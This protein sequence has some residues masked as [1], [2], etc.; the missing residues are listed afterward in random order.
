MAED[1][2]LNA[3]DYLDRFFDEL[4]AEVRANPKLAE[5]LV[6]SLGGQVV[7]DDETRADIAKPY[8]LA[9]SATKARFYAVFGAMKPGQLRKILRDNN[10]ATT[11]DMTGKSAQQLIDMMYDRALT[12]V[13]ERK[14]ST[15]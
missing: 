8:S 11:V 3:V 13:S 5:R 12:K 2:R 10:L 7:F 9:G 4:R 6:R 14:S 1:Q 15:F